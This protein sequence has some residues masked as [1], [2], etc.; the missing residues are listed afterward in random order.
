[1]ALGQRADRVGVHLLQ[2]IQWNDGQRPRQQLAVPL[3]V[4]C[5]VAA[6]RCNAR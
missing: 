3:R 1:M 4:V 2:Q 5:D 6:Q